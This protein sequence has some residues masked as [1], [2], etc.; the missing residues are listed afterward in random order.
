MHMHDLNTQTYMLAHNM[1][2]QTHRQRVEVGIGMTGNW[3]VLW[4]GGG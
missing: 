2:A 1:K 3:I 4:R